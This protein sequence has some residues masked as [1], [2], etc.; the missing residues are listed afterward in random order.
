MYKIHIIHNAVQK[1]ED[2]FTKICV[3]KFDVEE[4]AI[5]LYYW[6]DKSTKRKNGLLTYL[7]SVTRSTGPLL[8]MLQHVGSV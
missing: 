8:G 7:H 1:A 3:H 5:D 2:G 4:L 6:F